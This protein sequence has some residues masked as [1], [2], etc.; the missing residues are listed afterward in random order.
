M[1]FKKCGMSRKPLAEEFFTW[2]TRQTDKTLPQNLLGKALTYVKNQRKYLLAFL[3][4]GRIELSNNRA[5]RSIKP[6]VIGRKNR[7]FCNT[8][9]GAK[10]SAAIYGLNPQVYLEYIFDQIRQYGNVRKH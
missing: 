10:S 4:D 7:L 9:G 5:E 8:S 3:T 2:V 6:F 1:R